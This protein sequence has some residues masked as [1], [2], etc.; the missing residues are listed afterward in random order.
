DTDTCRLRSLCAAGRIGKGIASA[1]ERLTVERQL[2]SAHNQLQCAPSRSADTK[3]RVRRDAAETLLLTG[4]QPGELRLPSG[5]R[6]QRR[7]RCGPIDTCQALA[8]ACVFA[9]QPEGPQ[10]IVELWRHPQPLAACVG[11]AVERGLSL[12]G[13][14]VAPVAEERLL[15]GGLVRCQQS[16]GRAAGR[17]DIRAR[18]AESEAGQRRATGKEKWA[19]EYTGGDVPLTVAAEIGRGVVVAARA[20]GDAVEQADRIV[21]PYADEVAAKLHADVAIGHEIRRQRPFDEAVV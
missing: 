14:R 17:S 19:E 10:V 20:I 21:D 8:H 4:D 2:L 9:E 5:T 13:R 16:I 1:R 6:E 12:G 7:T 15:T 18:N 3:G 11:A